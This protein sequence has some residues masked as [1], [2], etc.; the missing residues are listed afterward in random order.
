VDAAYVRERLAGLA[1][2]SDLTKYI[3]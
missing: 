1:S 2:D 3:L